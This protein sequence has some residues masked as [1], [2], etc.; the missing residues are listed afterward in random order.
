MSY[1]AIPS[2]LFGVVLSALAGSVYYQGSV[3]SAVQLRW[4]PQA[5]F[6]LAHPGV[7]LGIGTLLLLA[8]FFWPT[9]KV[10]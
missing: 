6:L 3:E 7:A 2:M 1:V 10:E 9:E 8:G 4:L 5:D